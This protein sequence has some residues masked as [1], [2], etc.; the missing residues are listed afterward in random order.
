MDE[1]VKSGTD[2]HSVAAATREALQSF[3]TQQ[4]FA[5]AGASQT[6]LLDELDRH[7]VGIVQTRHEAA[8][9]AAADGYARAS[10]RLG[11]ALINVDQGVP[12]AVTGIQNAWESGAPV[13]V[14]VGRD[15]DPTL[16]P[17]QL[18]DH[19]ALALVRPISKWARA[20]HHPTR[21]PEYV[22][23]AGRRALAPRPGPTVITYAEDYLGE[24]M[25][26]TPNGSA[27]ARTPTAADAALIESCAKLLS[28]ARRPV[29]IA[30]SGAARSRAA[31]VLRQISARWQIPVL[32]NAMGRGLVPEDDRLGWS[33]PIA[34]TTV[35]AA[36]CVL[37]VGARLAK[38]FGY[39]LAPRFDAN[40]RMASIADDA[41]LDGRPRALDLE[42][43]GDPTLTLMGLQAAL[44]RRDVSP[45]DPTWLSEQLAPR[46]AAIAASGSDSV[47]NH[48]HPY[49]LAR[50]VQSQLGPDVQVICD[51]ASILGRMFA[52]LRC[53]HPYRYIDTYPLGSM[54]IGTPLTLGV[55][56]GSRSQNAASRTLLI[57]GDGAM[58]FY[59]AELGSLAQAGARATVVVANNG[60]WGNELQAQP[61]KIGRTVNARFNDVDYAQIARGFGCDGVRVD[62]LV[63]LTAAFE[64][65]ASSA[66]PFVIDA[67]VSE[68]PIGPLER[69]I[70]Y[71]ALQTARELHYS[72]L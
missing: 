57:T 52:V 8:T 44:V 22:L 50:A 66:R 54:G 48:I 38:R 6:A 42:L 33:W 3:G 67:V 25:P 21:L 10:G 30:G 34:Q 62:S 20:V 56:I 55:S 53:K 18:V 16:D 40:A 39:G 27:T 58:G 24:Q 9:V 37:W 13:I 19:D 72:Q 23:A 2:V 65:A 5:L 28:S 51:G 46:L 36:D 31:E 47:A 12:N 59:A 35:Q 17:E 64:Q 60:G 32:M 43:C 69:T 15:P 45:F 11:V 29:I 26:V 61:R 7:G 41:A 70:I 1:R 71:D 63:A 49:A 4:V 68:P 14:L